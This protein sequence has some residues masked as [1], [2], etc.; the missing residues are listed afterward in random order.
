MPI[1]ATIVDGMVFKNTGFRF[2]AMEWCLKTPVSGSLR[3]LSTNAVRL[4]G[5][6]DAIPS[7]S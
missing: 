4:G 2:I 6:R 5:A 7:V 3:G 1:A